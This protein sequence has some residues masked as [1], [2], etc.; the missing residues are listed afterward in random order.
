MGRAL[1]LVTCWILMLCAH[2]GASAPSPLP[3]EAYLWQRQWTPA[4]LRSIRESHAMFSGFRILAGES[5]RRGALH[6]IEPPLADLPK[7]E[8]VSVIAVIRLNGSD[9]SPDPVALRDRT[10]AIVHD[11]RAAGVPL[12]GIEIDHDCATARLA[13]YAR[14][15]HALHGDDWP[16]DVRL[17]IT[18]LPAWIG[19]TALPELLAQVD[20]SVLQVHA[21]RSPDSGLFDRTAARHWIDAYAKVSA[22]PFRV[23][24]PAYELRVQ[25]DAH[26]RAQAVEAEMQRDLDDRGDTR[27]L[28]APPRDVAELLH[29]LA[30][31]RPAQLTGIVWFRLPS[32]DDRHAWSLATL[33][34]VI[35][36]AELRANLQ[37][38][39]QTAADGA[40]DVVLSNRGNLDAELAPVMV[41]ADRC[42]AVDGAGGY[43][44]H[45]EGAAWRFDPP[46]RAVL[47]AGRARRVGWLRCGSVENATI[48][49]KADFVETADLERAIER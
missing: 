15:L 22:K 14:M 17:S 42:V 46:S 33:R 21:V 31:S 49:Q 29:S 2:R 28:R 40:S 19:A 10:H 4:L 38:A 26:G 34:A 36:A 25:F 35:A 3:H 20:E 18:A 43:G 45:Q 41:H 30:A 48:V 13:D 44:A 24:L 7:Y 23:S 16:D 32:E 8:R 9:P 47:R 37:V 39:L 27:Q 5:D 12:T 11:W 6:V 1:L